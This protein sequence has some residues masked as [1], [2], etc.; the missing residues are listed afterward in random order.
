[1][2]ADALLE[3]LDRIESRSEIQDLAMRYAV[4]LDS[5][6]LDA[7][8][9]LFVPERRDRLRSRLEV[10]V[11]GFGRSVHHQTG[12]LVEL[13]PIDRD[14][15]RGTAYARAEHEVGERWVV[16]AVCYFD[17]YRRL[18]GRW[19]FDRRREHHW[20]AADVTERPQAV[21]FSSWPLVGPATMPGGWAAR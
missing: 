14:R 8:A 12:H 16:M 4:A 18:D 10:V 9:E 17:E 6:D 21:D 19:Y 11:A 13:D 7:F 1:M 2:A 5:R 20:Y 15:A 3:R